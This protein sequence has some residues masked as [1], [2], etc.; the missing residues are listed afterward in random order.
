[1][2]DISR[3]S[4]EACLAVKSAWY[5]WLLPFTASFSPWH[6]A[7]VRIRVTQTHQCTLV[8]PFATLAGA[9]TDW[10][11]E[12]SAFAPCLLPLSSGGS[13]GHGC[14][15][16]RF[17]GKLTCWVSLS[18]IIP[19]LP[20]V[21]SW[22]LVRARTP[23]SLIR[24]QTDPLGV[25]FFRQP[26]VCR[27]PQVARE[28]TDA[29]L[30]NHPLVKHPYNAAQ[31]R[32]RK[33]ALMSLL[34]RDTSQEEKDNA[35]R[36][37]K[38]RWITKGEGRWIPYL[39]QSGPPYLDSP[40]TR[41]SASQTL[42]PLPPQSKSPLL[43]LQVLEQARQIEERRR[44]E[45]AAAQAAA[46]AAAQARRAAAPGAAARG[47]SGA[48]GPDS[49]FD[50]S[51][52]VYPQSF[53]NQVGSEVVVFYVHMVISTGHYMAVGTCTLLAQHAPTLVH[54]R[55]CR[56]SPPKPQHELAGC[57]CLPAVRS[58]C[59][60]VT[61]ACHTHAWPMRPWPLS[62]D[63]DRFEQVQP[64]VPTLLSPTLEP[65]RPERPGVYARGVHMRAMLEQQ[66]VAILG[67][68]AP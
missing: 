33:A 37:T 28:G 61:P 3:L 54:Q 38:G 47:G 4:W 51:Y 48:P 56:W 49:A 55:L 59:P 7:V 53:D 60:G 11:A 14:H 62:F 63:S 19:L 52:L 58:G 8:I 25:A 36:A 23:H 16:N 10:S 1:M 22:W 9:Q 57:V 15:P 40:T 17:A 31:D 42:T 6:T 26:S 46:A 18:F 30:A 5:R 21:L 67:A 45:Q 24:R 35:V 20:A 34:D 12:C 32:Q 66:P 2:P 39:P 50:P 44:A 64:G 65:F 27:S 13:W 68:Q 43:P 41:T 29:T